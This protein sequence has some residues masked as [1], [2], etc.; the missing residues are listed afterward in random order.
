M[1]K[2]ALKGWLDEGEVLFGADRS[3]WRFICPACGHIQTVKEMEDAGRDPQN[4]YQECIGR[5]TGKGSPREGDTS[6]CNWTAY[7]LLGT[8]GRGR[9]VISET[10]REVEVFAFAPYQKDPKEEMADGSKKTL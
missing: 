9:I 3:K 1:N 5:Y 7:G 4:A 2:T 10:G 6:G 8:L